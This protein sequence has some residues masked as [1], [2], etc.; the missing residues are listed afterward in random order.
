MS[1]S[2]GDWKVQL[3]EDSVKTLLFSLCALSLCS[4]SVGFCGGVAC[5]PDL[6]G[7]TS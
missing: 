3:G 5:G 4:L 6:E 7:C 2:L 1:V